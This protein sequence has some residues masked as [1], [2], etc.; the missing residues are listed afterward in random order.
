MRGDVAELANGFPMRSS[1]RRN[2]AGVDQGLNVLDEPHIKKAA[3][4]VLFFRRNSR[5]FAS[6]A[7]RSFQHPVALLDAKSDKRVEE[8]TVDHRAARD[9]KQGSNLP[10]NIGAELRFN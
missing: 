3:F 4:L 8:P 6:L 1:C 7:H 9:L 5:L 2:N 10:R